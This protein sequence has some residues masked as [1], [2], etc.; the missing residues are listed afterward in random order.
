MSSLVRFD[1]IRRPFGDPVNLHRPPET[2]LLGM[3]QLAMGGCRS[4]G[5]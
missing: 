1:D 2:L 5:C 4:S 3:P